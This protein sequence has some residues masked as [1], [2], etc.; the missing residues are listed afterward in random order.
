MSQIRKIVAGTLVGVLAVLALPGVAQAAGQ[1]PYVRKGS[2]CMFT[3]DRYAV[4]MSGCGLVGT[5][6][7]HDTGRTY[8]GHPLVK[9]QWDWAAPSDSVCLDSLAQRSGSVHLHA[10]NGGDYQ[11]LEVFNGPVPGSKVL[12]SIGAWTHQ[13]VHI[14]LSAG[15]ANN[16]TVVWATC[17][18]NASSQQFNWNP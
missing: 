6:R 8:N 9:I 17:N 10:C 15:S 4:T 1:S 2:Y 14:C 7:R 13:G 18:T 12:K 3:P 11:L 5:L 16:A